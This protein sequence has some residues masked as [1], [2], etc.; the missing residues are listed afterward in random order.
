MLLSWFVAALAQVILT[1]LA[2]VLVSTLTGQS[3]IAINCHLT[4]Y[5]KTHMRL[6]AP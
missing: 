5:L 2:A 4:W 3:T 6:S 1:P